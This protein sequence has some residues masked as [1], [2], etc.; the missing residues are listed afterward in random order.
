M[1]KVSYLRYMETLYTIGQLARAVGV[2]ISTVRYYERVGLLRPAGRTGGNYR[3]YREEAV[4]RLRFIRAAQAT[5]F[6]LEDVTA[7]LQL[8][9]GTAGICEDVQTLVEDRLSDLEKRMTDLRLV[10]R[11]LKTTLKRCRATGWS[12]HCHVID[13][14]TAASA[15]HP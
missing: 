13:G 8:R 7:L 14:L 10:Q 4:E 9:E 1:C 2:P 5:G 15:S 6:T 3:L 11:V 12:G